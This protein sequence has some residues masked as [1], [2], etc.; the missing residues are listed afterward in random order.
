MN[1]II[2]EIE[3]FSL[4]DGPGIRTAVFLKGCN[5]S[6]LWCHN[7]ETVSPKPELAVEPEN[8]INCLKCAEVCPLGLHKVENGVNTAFERDKCINCG[9][10]KKCAGVCFANALVMVGKEM[11]VDAVLAE[12]ERDRAYYQNS[13]GGVTL[14]GG[15]VLTQAGFA[16][17]L[18]KKCKESG[19][20]TAIETN[21]FA[22]FEIIESML[23]FIDLV[24]LDIKHI[25]G[26]I[27]K[28]YTGVSNNTVLEN[29]IKLDNDGVPF[30]VRT[31]VIPG[32][33]YGQNIEEVCIE[34]ICEFLSNLK[35]LKY[36][37]LLDFNPLGEYK[38]KKLGLYNTFENTMPQ[39]HEKLNSLSK[40]LQEKYNIEVR[41]S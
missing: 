25:D 27:H 8:C 20:H 28:K 13:G 12:I 32:V 31:P 18:L 14:T 15:E 26:E 4:K 37:E 21:F 11:S 9:D 38:Y 41:V 30:I 34:G 2:T 19:F 40:A 22:D 36:Y 35:N 24:M 23:P 17:R 1:G 3:R 39:G 5:M 10:C 29:V 33:N 16:L 7:P 6:C